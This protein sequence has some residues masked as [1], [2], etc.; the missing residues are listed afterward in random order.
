MRKAMLMNH[1]MHHMYCHQ[2]RH[3]FTKEEKK[4]YLEEYKQWLENEKK[5]VEEALSELTEKS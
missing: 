2:N 3:F 5:G 1:G 4:A